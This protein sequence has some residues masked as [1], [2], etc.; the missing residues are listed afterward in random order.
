MQCQDV[1][2][3]GDKT[4]IRHHDAWF[5]KW[6]S[7]DKLPVSLPNLPTGYTVASWL[8]GESALLTSVNGPETVDPL[9]KQYI[10]VAIVVPIIFVALFTG[11]GVLCFLKRRK[12]NRLRPEQVSL[13]ELSGR[14]RKDGVVNL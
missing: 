9:H 5:I 13:Q 4:Q 1:K 6:Q 11:C 2:P 14:V 12:R 7:S 8:P 3:A 10:T